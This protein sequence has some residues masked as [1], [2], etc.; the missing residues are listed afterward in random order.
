[1]PRRQ[2]FYILVKGAGA[3]GKLPNANFPGCKPLLVLRPC[4]VEGVCV[5]AN[6]IS[7]STHN[8]WLCQ[9]E[10]S[11][12]FFQRIRVEYMHIDPSSRFWFPG[13]GY[14]PPVDGQQL[15]ST[16]ASQHGHSCLAVFEFQTATRLSWHDS[17]PRFPFEVKNQ[18]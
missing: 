4:T 7:A 5:V 15:F 2:F 18:A 10:W 13:I 12:G 6:Q 16:C 17:F 3:L 9:W 14:D 1:M 11:R 8:S